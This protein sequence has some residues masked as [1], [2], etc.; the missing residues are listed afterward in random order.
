MDRPTKEEV[1]EALNSIREDISHDW[2]HFRLANEVLALREE[3]QLYFQLFGSMSPEML[4]RYARYPTEAVDVLVREI[5]IVTLM[6]NWANVPS[7]ERIFD[8]AH[9]VRASR[10]PKL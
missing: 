1:D 10:E 3:V 9:A 2:R 7:I 8:A 5:E 6:G 4:T